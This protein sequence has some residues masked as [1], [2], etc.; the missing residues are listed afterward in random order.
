MEQETVTKINELEERYLNINDPSEK[1]WIKFVITLARASES[2][3]IQ[4]KL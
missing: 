4:T 2:R 3:E 1:L